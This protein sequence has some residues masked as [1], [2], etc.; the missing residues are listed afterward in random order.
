M[1]YLMN[2]KAL[3]FP[4]CHYQTFP[5]VY[6]TISIALTACRSV[7]LNVELRVIIH[8][9]SSGT[10]IKYVI[11]ER[12]INLRYIPLEFRARQVSYMTFIE[13]MFSHYNTV[14]PKSHFLNS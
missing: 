5:S 12:H 9:V 6:F 7:W 2:I 11:V 13:L 4:V 1:M 10:L 8:C 14:Q 3:L